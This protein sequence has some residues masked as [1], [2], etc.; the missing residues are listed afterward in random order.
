MSRERADAKQVKT[1]E[2]QK[3]QRKMASFWYAV[4]S[5]ARTASD[6]ALGIYDAAAG[7]VD[8][9]YRAIF[10]E[11]EDNPDWSNQG[12][13]TEKHIQFC[14]D[15]YAQQDEFVEEAQK[16]ELEQEKRV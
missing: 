7:G 4:S 11:Y 1:G 12:K 16:C 3:F 13:L 2:I 15:V 6:T 9:L 10:D 8:E 5:I 14:E